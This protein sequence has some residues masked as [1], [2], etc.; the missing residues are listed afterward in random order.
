MTKLINMKGAVALAM[1]LSFC[2][3]SVAFTPGV[4]L[5]PDN[6]TIV[7]KPMTSYEARDIKGGIVA[8]VIPMAWVG[9]ALAADAAIIVGGFA[10]Y[11]A[12]EVVRQLKEE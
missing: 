12:L 11:G 9:Y 4:A 6:S 10:L 1:V 8:V 3:Y 7:S 2:V 5:T